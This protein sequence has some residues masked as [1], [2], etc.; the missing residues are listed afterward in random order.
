MSKIDWNL[1][2]MCICVIVLILTFCHFVFIY[3]K[4]IPV[5]ERAEAK[6]RSMGGVYGG[7]KCF[8]NG[9]EVDNQ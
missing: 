2:G 9:F 6:C 7:G 1:I 4:S 8:V 3:T 5:T